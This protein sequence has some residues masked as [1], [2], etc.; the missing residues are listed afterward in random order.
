MRWLTALGVR[1]LLHPVWRVTRGLTLGVC[2]VVVDEAGAVVLVEHSYRPGWHLP[3]GGVEHGETAAD[4]IIRE[5]AEEA[6]V[7]PTAEPELF[8]L[9]AN[10][11]H[12]KGNHVALFVVRDWEPTGG[13]P[14]RFEILRTGRFGADALPEATT[15][16]ARRRIGEVLGGDPPAS[17]W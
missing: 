6:A 15:P 5:L 4:A 16:A 1:L 17:T 7:R 13:S 9:Y 12:M 8:A 14:R 11:R 2:A 3:G 10:F